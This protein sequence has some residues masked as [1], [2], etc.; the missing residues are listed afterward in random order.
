M[1]GRSDVKRTLWGVEVLPPQQSDSVWRR[2]PTAAPLPVTTSQPQPAAVA[3]ATS[4]R[5]T[6]DAAACAATA[7]QP[8]TGSSLHF[9]VT[10]TRGNDISVPSE[11][12]HAVLASLR[13]G[14]GRGASSV[15][16]L[17]VLWAG[18]LLS[19]Q[20]LANLRRR[21]SMAADAASSWVIP[22]A[23]WSHDVLHTSGGYSFFPLG[24]GRLLVTVWCAP[25]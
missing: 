23:E 18:Q 19:H 20:W 5:P 16:L 1:C 3:P 4:E 10:V 24:I 7:T 22:A 21:A 13:D 2:L 17:L 12:A 15:K 9:D 8:A 6:A 25:T 14:Q 11:V